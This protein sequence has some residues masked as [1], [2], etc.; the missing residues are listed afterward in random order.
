ML[1]GLI[2]NAVLYS[3]GMSQSSR[4]FMLYSLLNVPNY[5]Y[6]LSTLLTSISVNST[7]KTERIK[8]RDKIRANNHGYNNIKE[9]NR[10]I[11]H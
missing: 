2:F 1:I 9:I 7:I 3:N 8:N 5:S 6:P 11:N 4:D 10:F